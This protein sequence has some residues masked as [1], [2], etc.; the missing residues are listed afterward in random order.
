MTTKVISGAWNGR[1]ASPES[2]GAGEDVSEALAV[3][4]APEANEH[5]TLGLVELLLKDPDRVDSLSREA[6]RHRELIPRFLGIALGSYLLYSAAMLVILNV[7]PA[8][9][10]PRSLLPMPA[11]RWS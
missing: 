6:A 9:A 8:G 2:G 4:A 11:A 5:A 10:W 7:S 1:E 3:E